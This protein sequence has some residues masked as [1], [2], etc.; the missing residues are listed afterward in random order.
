MP[1]MLKA[2]N[3]EEYVSLFPNEIAAIL[4]TVRHLIRETVPNAIESISYG[5]PAYKLQGK[6]LVYFAA[7]AKHLGVYATPVA[8]SAFEEAL[9]PYKRGKGSVQFPFNKPIPY[10]LIK[11]MVLFR[12]KAL[13]ATD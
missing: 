12:A 1:K 11:Q 10:D 8:H 6:P 13:M 9:K 5:M 2:D 7:Q 3:V 4:V